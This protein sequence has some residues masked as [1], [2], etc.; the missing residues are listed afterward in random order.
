MRI[1]IELD[2]GVTAPALQISTQGKT[3]TPESSRTAASDTSPVA[4][5]DAGAPA[6]LASEPTSQPTMNLPPGNVAE[7]EAGGASAGSAPGEE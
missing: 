2:A 5:T 1:I 3:Q 4:V 7:G 6:Y